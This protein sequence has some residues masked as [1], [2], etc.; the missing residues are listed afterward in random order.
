MSGLH[1]LNAIFCYIRSKIRRKGAW[2]V[3]AALLYLQHSAHADVWAF[4]DAK[5]VAHFAAERQDARYELFFKGST[6]DDTP[7][8]AAQNPQVSTAAAPAATSAATIASAPPF[9]ESARS[10]TEAAASAKLVAYFQVSPSFK[11]VAYLMRDAANQHS[12][13]FELL[14]AVIATESGFDARAVSQRGALGLMQITPQMAQQYGLQGTPSAPLAQRLLE[15]RT[16]IALGSRYLRDL[17]GQFGGQLEL[18]LAAYNA[19][20]G[21]VERAGKRVPDYPETQN[22]VKTVL[23]IY[24]SLKPP[25]AVAALRQAGR[26]PLAPLTP[27]PTANAVPSGFLGGAQGR[28]NMVAPLRSAAAT[29]EFP[30]QRD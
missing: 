28:A 6:Q 20:P 11:A 12:I 10:K 29:P 19:G 2:A 27:S 16:N 23:Q 8:A 9:S 21:A 24:R 30:V 18:A 13:D 15:P 3:L 7:H 17:L 5:G 14:Q 22:Y 25:Q 26:S 4:I 1:M